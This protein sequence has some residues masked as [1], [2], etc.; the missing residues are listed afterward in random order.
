MRKYSQEELLSESLWNSVKSVGRV[1]NAGFRTA[2]SLTGSALD[3][4]APEVT[5]PYRRTKEGI[6]KIGRD[7]SDAFTRGIKGPMGLVAKKLS[8][9]GYKLDTNSKFKRITGGDV[10]VYAFPSKGLDP[11]TGKTIWDKKSTPLVV[12]P[13]TGYISKNLRNA[14]NLH[15]PEYVPTRSHPSKSKK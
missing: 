3:I 8:E 6:K 15:N 5:N 4:V 13:E 14:Q 10:M 12:D 9:V 7:A 1:A 11:K 2:K